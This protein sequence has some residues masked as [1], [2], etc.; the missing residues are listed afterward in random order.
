MRRKT[1]NTLSGLQMRYTSS[2]KAKSFSPF[3][4]R[5]ITGADER[6]MHGETEEQR[7]ERITLVTTLSLRYVLQHDGQNTITCVHLLQPSQH[8]VPRDQIE[9]TMPSRNDGDTHSVP[10][11]V[12]NAYWYGAVA[13]CTVSPI[14]CAVVLAMSLLKTSPTTHTTVWFRECCDPLHSERVPKDVWCTATRHFHCDFIE[15]LAVTITLEQGS[16]V[17][18]GHP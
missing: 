18:H 6:R 9:R 15:Q 1:S 3:L 2:K 5:S 13:L 14:S 10:A 12:F 17:F 4:R 7:H 16:Q 8:C 11:L